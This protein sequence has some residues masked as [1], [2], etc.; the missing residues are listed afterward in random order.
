MTKRVPK[1]GPHSVGAARQYC[2]ALGKVANCQVAVT[3]ALCVKQAWPVGALLYRPETWTSDARRRAAARI[4]VPASFRR[5][6][7]S[8]W[9]WCAGR[10]R[11]A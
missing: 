7:A 11:P 1:S 6:G 3:A 10:E 2:G 9:R 5:R 8:P 4:P